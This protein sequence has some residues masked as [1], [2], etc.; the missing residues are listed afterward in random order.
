MVQITKDQNDFIRRKMRN[1]YI[2]IC[3]K[4]KHGGKGYRGSGKTY[5]CP[6]SYNYIRLINA[7]ND[8]YCK[9]VEDYGSK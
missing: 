9:V 4:R 8:T 7:F 2:V 6:D 3:S 5:Y 1:P